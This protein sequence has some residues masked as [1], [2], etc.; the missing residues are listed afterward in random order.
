MHG[1]YAHD[2]FNVDVVPPSLPYSK[3]NSRLYM[4]EGNEPVIK[5]SIKERAPQFRHIPRTHRIKY[6]WV[7]ERLKNDRSI[8]LKYKR[9]NQ[10]MADMLTKGHFTVAT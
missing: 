8:F 5:M 3:G 10:Q 6:A 7:L 2:P 1:S 4:F 9:T